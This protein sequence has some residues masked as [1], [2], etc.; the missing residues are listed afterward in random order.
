MNEGEKY[1]LLKI[2]KALTNAFLLSIMKVIV[3]YY[4][5]TVIAHI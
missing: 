2:K 3:H 5:Y 4:L 1:Q